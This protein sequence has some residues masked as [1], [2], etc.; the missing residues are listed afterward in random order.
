MSGR[1]LR[2]I[3]RAVQVAWF[4]RARSLLPAWVLACA[5]VLCTATPAR[6][7]DVRPRELR[8]CV[9]PPGETLDRWVFSSGGKVLTERWALQVYGPRNNPVYVLDPR[10]R[11]IS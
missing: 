1:Q 11:A 9:R 3:L 8:V 5:F 7:E 4:R 10:A 6:A 2:W